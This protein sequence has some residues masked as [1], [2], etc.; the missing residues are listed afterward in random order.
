MLGPGTSIGHAENFPGRDHLGRMRQMACNCTFMNLP[1]Q[2]DGTLQELPPAPPRCGSLVDVQR[3]GRFPH[4][5]LQHLRSGRGEGSTLAA[6]LSTMVT[7]AV[8]PPSL[9]RF[10]RSVEIAQPYFTMKNERRDGSI[11]TL[12]RIDRKFVNLPTLVLLSPMARNPCPATTFPS[13]LPLTAPET[14]ALRT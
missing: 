1:C 11:H 3:R 13:G 12:S 8:P 9:P 7:P 4:G 14:A 6:R 5:R 2:P 10:S